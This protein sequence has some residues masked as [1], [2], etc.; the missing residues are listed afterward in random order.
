M[1]PE[2]FEFIENARKPRG[3]RF[4]NQLY[5]F[6][7]CLVISVFI[8]SLVRLSK[9]YVYTVPYNVRYVNTPS[10]LRLVSVSDTTIKL[11]IRVQGFDFFS[12]RFFLRKSRLIDISLQRVKLIKL[13]KF[14]SGYLLTSRIGKEI[15]DQLIYP[16][17][18]YSYSPD[19]LFFVFERK[20]R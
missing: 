7:V 12:E 5:V 14:T 17:E 3:Q 6:L 9:E 8:W 15:S 2:F 4:R 10:N 11:N 19:T 16:L 13:E 18:I 20:R 1:K